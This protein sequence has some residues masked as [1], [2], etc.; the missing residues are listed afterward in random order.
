M[1]T[2]PVLPLVISMALPMTISMLVNALYNIVD[3]FFVAKISDDAMTALS[4]VYPIQNLMMA[5]TVGFGIGINA[6]IAYFLGA[7]REKEA[8]ISASVGVVCNIFHGLLL[9]IGCILVMPAFL[10]MFTK[11]ATI[12]DL[13]LQYSNI[14]FLFAIPVSISISLE[15]IFQSVGRMRTSMFCMIIGCIA[16]VVLDPLLIF[17]IGVFPK[18][19]IEGAAIATGVGEMVTLAGYIIIY[20]VKPISVRINIC[21]VKF[22]ANI[23]KRMYAIGVPATLNMALPSLQISVLNGILAVYSSAYVLVLGAYFKLQTFLYLTA[24]GVVQGMRPLLAYNYGAGEKKRV[25]QIYKTALR[26]IAGVMVVGTLLCMSVPDKLI[27]LFTNNAQTIKIGQNALRMISLGFVVSSVS[28]TA[29]GAL[30]GLGKGVRSLVI[31]L[32]RYL[33]IMLP[34]A[35]ILSRSFGPSGVWSAFWITEFITAVVAHRLYAQCQDTR[36]KKSETA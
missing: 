24:N 20:F 26:I 23:L 27:G 10:K 3:S 36:S 30:E 1:R 9:T 18:M 4:L 13:G 28:V 11:D 21:Y 17:G 14:V 15:K 29:S 6:M 35:F 22:R 2:R 16:N 34:V 12:I 32:M 33:L 31:S 8:N 5:T 25:N 7:K 19:G